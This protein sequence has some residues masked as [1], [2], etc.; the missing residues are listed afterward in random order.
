MTALPTFCMIS[1]NW[2]MNRSNKGNNETGEINFIISVSG[3]T[4]IEFK[5]NIEIQNQLNIYN[6]IK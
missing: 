2:I 5:R 3:L 1:E 6:L 4:L